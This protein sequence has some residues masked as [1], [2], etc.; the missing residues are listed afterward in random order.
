MDFDFATLTSKERYKLLVGA[1]V[2]RPI[3]WV[4]TLNPSGT[5]NLAPFSAFNYMGDDPGVVAFSPH[6]SKH[7]FKNLEREREFVVNLVPHTLA[8]AMNTTAIDFPESVSELEHIAV[9]TAPG[10]QVRTP[11]VVESP[12][13]LEC[14]VHT[15]VELGNTRVVVGQVLHYHIADEFLDRERL[16]VRTAALDLIGRTGGT[17]QY[18]TTRDPFEVPRMTY[19]QWLEGAGE[20]RKAKGEGIL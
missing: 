13:N 15:V 11:R 12:V 9:T 6:P 8:E 5:L 16:Y 7:T 3:A 2:P 19:Q 1:I 17:A 18:V 20:G 10:V 14:R 4:S